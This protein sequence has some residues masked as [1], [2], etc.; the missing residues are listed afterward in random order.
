MR[1]YK[2]YIWAGMSAKSN[3]DQ[4]PPWPKL[5][6]RAFTCRV[7]A[8]AK[9]KAVEV[10]VPAAKVSADNAALKADLKKADVVSV[11]RGQ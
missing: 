9:K 1:T 8:T 10:K 7:Q 5:T 6:G 3:Y 4:N 11:G 2:A